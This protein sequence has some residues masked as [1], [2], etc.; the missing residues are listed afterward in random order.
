MPITNAIP[1]QSNAPNRSGA[2]KA[3]LTSK[4]IKS[5]KADISKMQPIKPVSSPIIEKIKSDSAN[6]KNKYFCL[7][8]K[9]PT[10]NQPPEPK[11]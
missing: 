4:K 2:F 8:L 1:A 11:P 9:S 7:E 3:I 10:P 6:G 5:A